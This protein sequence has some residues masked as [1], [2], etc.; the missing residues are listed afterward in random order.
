MANKQLT[1]SVKLNTAQF[2]AKLKRI[3]KGIDALNRA[4]GNQSRAYQQVNATL[5][6]TTKITAKVK[7][8]TDENTNSTNRWA[9]ATNKVTSNLNNSSNSLSAI[10]KKLK[11]IAATYLGVMGAKAVIGTSDTITS[12]ENRINALNGGDTV[13]TQEALDKMYVSAQKVRMSYADMI[14]NAS[15]SM[16]LAGD[17][18]QG[19]MDNAIR[20]QEIMSEAYTLGGASAQE[21]STSM[22]QMI[23]ALGAGILAGDELRSVREGAP[24]AYKAIEEFAQGIYKTD[25][26]LKE[27][28]SQ[29]KVTSDMVVAAIMNS[30]EKLDEQFKKTKVTFAQAWDQIKNTAV[31]AFEPAL[32]SLNKMLNSDAGKKTIDGIVKALVVLGNT[33]SW[34]IDRLSDFFNWCVDNWYWLKYVVAG[35]VMVIIALLVKMAAVAI[36]NGIAMAASWIMANWG[37]LLIIAALVLLFAFFEEVCGAI[38]WT[39]ALFKNVGLAVANFFIALWNWLCAAFNNVVEWIVTAF[40][41]CVNWIVNF[42]MGLWNSIKAIAQN[43]GIAF[44]NAW[45]GAQNAF[46]GFIKACLE[47][48][49]WLEPAINAIAKAF[50]AEGF[51]LSGVIDNVAGKQKSYKEFVSVSDAWNTGY[52]TRAY[53]SGDYQSLTDAWNKG[54]STYDVFQDGWGKDAYST[55]AEWGANLKNSL[56]QGNDDDSVLGLNGSNPLYSVADA[57]N[58][59]TADELLNGVKDTA[60]NT[61]KIADSMDLTAED[62]DYLRRIADMEWKKEYTT[63]QIVLNMENTNTINNKGDLDGWVSD[64]RDLLEEEL[65]AVANGVYA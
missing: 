10:G 50:G 56:F 1:A 36:A 23:Q 4:V 8:K 46:W 15:K 24:L 3:A 2:E 37:L 17:A 38:F 13:A 57:Y 32:Q 41:N 64:L 18:F 9:N 55:G 65:T 52:T 54:M 31:K 53:E 40:H 14:S 63:A 16:T 28:A 29:G 12:A 47:G 27:L 45:I 44:E 48:V 30:G 20:F 43:I 58:A 51:T 59:P 11:S 6:Q 21:M 60:D 5:G 25:E 33:V 42:A 19:N 7:Q 26:S 61:G 22:Y 34:I 49:R 62:L 39:G 35:V